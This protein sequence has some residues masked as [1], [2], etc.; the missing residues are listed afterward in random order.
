M[1]NLIRINSHDNKDNVLELYD[2]VQDSVLLVEA[3]NSIQIKNRII[4][5]SN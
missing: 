4:R 5:K 3:L 1:E 2:C